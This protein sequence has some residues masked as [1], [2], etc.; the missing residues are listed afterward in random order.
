M[1]EEER[2]EKE[3]CELLKEMAI[4]FSGNFPLFFLIFF[5]FLFHFF[6]LFS[7]LGS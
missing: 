2:K 6:L 5:F 7:S 1:G 3:K 4:R